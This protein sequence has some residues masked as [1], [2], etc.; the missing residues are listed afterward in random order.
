[1]N[2]SVQQIKD[3]LSIVDVISPYVELHQAGKNMKGKSPFTSEKTPS[4]YVSV[5]RGMYYC[6]SSSQGGD[7]FTFI[8]K[9]EGVDFKGALKILAEKAGVELTKEDPK[10][11]NERDKQYAILEMA[12]AFF[13]EKLKEDS[14][15]YAYIIARGLNKET[16]KKWRIGYAPGPPNYGWRELREEL[17]KKNFNDAEGVRAGLVKEPGAGKAP[18]DLFR[19]RI[20]FPI[21]DPSGRVIAF[22]GRILSKDTESPKYVN[23]PDTELFNKSEALYGYH[24]AK[25]GIRTLGFSLVVEGQFDVVLAHQVGYKNTVAVSGT[26]LT[27]HHVSLL[28]RLSSKVV[29]ALDSDQAGMRAAVRAAEV[30]LQRGVDLKVASL[31]AGKDPAD[32]IKEDKEEF[33]KIIKQ[34]KHVIEYLL[35]VIKEETNDQ[36]AYQLR[37]REEILPFILMIDNHIDRDH[38]SGVIAEYLDT[39]KDAI[40]LELARIESSKDTKR[41]PQRDTL[42]SPLEEKDHTPS[43]RKDRVIAFLL[44]VA[45]QLDEQLSDKIKAALQ[46]VTKKDIDTLQSEVS[47]ELMNKLNFM[48]E[49]SFLLLSRRYQIEELQDRLVELQ[50][51]LHKESLATLKKQ[52]VSAEQQSDEERVAEVMRQINEL[53]M[54]SP[55]ES[56]FDFKN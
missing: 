52:L 32:L 39:T 54:S 28:Q 50:N 34:S 9:M 38:F 53:Q 21:S 55:E 48:T 16:I 3:R 22:S 46:S 18:Y 1:M 6:F 5:D 10:K 33:K 19:D 36:R 26:A 15:A 8:E 11:R 30:M 49:D 35:Q 12:T 47:A 42:S 24:E 25:N 23:T 44:T 40:L 13:E 2:D 56:A 29:L 45:T 7:I 27:A 31:P 37:A 41:E 4:F 43:A 20:M 51:I 14:E 17:Q